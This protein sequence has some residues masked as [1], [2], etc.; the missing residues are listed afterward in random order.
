MVVYSSPYLVLNLFPKDIEGKYLNNILRRNIC[1]RYKYTLVY[2]IMQCKIRVEYETSS[3]Y[4][5]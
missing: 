3:Q 5:K 1:E 4:L 2:L